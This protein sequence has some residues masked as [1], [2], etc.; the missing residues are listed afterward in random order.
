LKY[1]KILRVRIEGFCVQVLVAPAKHSVLEAPSLLNLS[2]FLLIIYLFFPIAAPKTLF[3]FRRREPPRFTTFPFSPQTYVQYWPHSISHCFSF[4]LLFPVFSS[5]TSSRTMQTKNIGRQQPSVQTAASIKVKLSLFS[6][7][8]SIIYK[9]FFHQ[10]PNPRAHKAMLP[11]VV[12][13]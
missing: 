8:S 1:Y 12:S 3:T 13:V 9:G 5:N 11:Q 2:H 10:Q 6:K 4:L 7:L